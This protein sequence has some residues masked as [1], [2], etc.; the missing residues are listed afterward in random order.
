M[1]FSGKIVINLGFNCNFRCDHCANGRETR[2]KLSS[3]EISAVVSAINKYGARRIHFIGGEPTLYLEDIRAI[4]ARTGA[5]KNRKVIVTT[6]GSFAA[7]EAAAVFVLSSIPHLQK[8]Q[9]SYDKFHARFLPLSKIKNLY[10][11]CR[12]MGLDFGMLSAIQSPTDMVILRSVNEIGRFPISVQKVLPQGNAVKTGATYACYRTLEKK[13][14]KGRCPD[15]KNL[16]YFC[17]KGFT[18]CCSSL[19]LNTGIKGICHKTPEGLFRSKF[20]KLIGKHNFGELAELA[21][22]SVRELK[23]EHSSPCNL[24]EHIFKSGLLRR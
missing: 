12:K 24:C 7:S 14:L 1:T 22:I 6:N 3:A 15:R 2:K 16:I 4:L 20:H 5:G 13:V 17:G 9:L 8:V 18:S 23:P 21:G 11:V 19:I 10:A